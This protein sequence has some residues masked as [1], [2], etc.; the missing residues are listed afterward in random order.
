MSKKNKEHP[1]IDFLLKEREEILE[2]IKSI[3]NLLL[4][5]ASENSTLA[6]TLASQLETQASFSRIAKWLDS[7]MKITPRTSKFRVKK[8][9]ERLEDEFPTIEVAN[10]DQSEGNIDNIN[11]NDKEQKDSV[12]ILRPLVIFIII[13]R[14]DTALI[15]HILTHNNAAII[16][17]HGAL[18]RYSI[19]ALSNLLIRPDKQDV[20]LKLI[21]RRTLPDIANFLQEC[22][23][24]TKKQVN[25]CASLN[26]LRNGLAHRNATVISKALLGGKSIS[27]FELDAIVT[28]D[29][30]FEYFIRTIH[31]W[32][33]LM[34]SLN[35]AYNLE[36]F[37]LG[38]LNEVD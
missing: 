7:Q 38:F 32:I 35:E 27:N 2:Q 37:P 20:G 26:K 30:F 8:I 21:E 3:D 9:L 10:S 22:K 5:K 29:I 36:D 14:L 13:S 19:E 18:E 33:Q 11:S 25:F 34:E 31:I 24:L 16:E 17:L 1:K 6:K 15:L 28:D 4:S 12:R 23:A